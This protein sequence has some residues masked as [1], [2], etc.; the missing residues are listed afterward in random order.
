MGTRICSGDESEL[1]GEYYFT[2]GK[3]LKDP[4]NEKTQAYLHFL[5]EE[6]KKLRPN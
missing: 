3:T 1:L 6:G 2:N 5:E 4:T